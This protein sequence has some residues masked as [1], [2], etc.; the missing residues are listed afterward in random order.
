[1]FLNVNTDVKTTAVN[2]NDVCTL[3]GNNLSSK[4]SISFRQ[5]GV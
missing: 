3:D 5:A 1:M 4:D 2:S